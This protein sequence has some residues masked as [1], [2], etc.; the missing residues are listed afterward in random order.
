MLDPL[1]VAGLA[2]AIFEQLLKLGERRREVISDIRSFEQDWQQ[3]R[4]KVRHQ[5]WRMK[6]LHLLFR[7][8]RIY[9]GECLV[10]QFDSDAQG[11]IHNYLDELYGLLERAL[12]MLK[13]V[14]GTENIS[15]TGLDSGFPSS[16]TT[17]VG[18]QSVL[19]IKPPS[20]LQPSPSEKS[21]KRSPLNQLR[22]SFRDKK[23]MVAI[24]G[25]FAEVNNELLE[26]VR[27]WSLAS[28]IGVDIRH[29]EHLRTDQDAGK[30]GLHDDASLALTVAD[31]KNIIESFELED[32]WSKVLK[33]ARTVE[34]RFA[35]F[36]WNKENMLRESCTYSQ[37]HE[38]KLDPQTRNRI[39]LLAKL[40]YQ[41]KETFFCIPP[42][43]GWSYCTNSNQI[44]YL[45]KLPSDLRLE[46]KSLLLL[47]KNPQTQPPLGTKFHIAHSLARSIAQLHLVQWVHE[48][49]RS[50]NILFFPSNAI[51]V[52][53]DRQDEASI[54][55]DLTR[56]LIFGF[57]FSRPDSFFSAGFIDACPDRDVYRHPE[58]QGQ[59]LTIFKKIHDI[60]SLGIILLEI[61]IWRPAIML[62][63]H[64]FAHARDSQG[65]PCGITQHLTKHAMKHLEKP[66]GAK[67]RDIVLK[68]ISGEFGVSNDTREDLKLQQAFRIQ[69]VEV[70]RKIVETL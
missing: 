43:Q 42:C 5:I 12:R 24:I 2:L 9:G 16:A 19:S 49:F 15:Q 48:S 1:S 50:E 51:E 33:E 66:M 28:A 36:D 20:P 56:P 30:L 62:E 41:P 57:E 47:L 68:C 3:L 44:S 11:Q 54:D 34:D 29:L 8:F 38:S 22:W 32:A 6:S 60:Y 55:V 35:V 40:L 7:D 4:E 39:N 18:V 31:T 21:V 52:D 27:F 46:P 61:G 14:A 17:L 26:M 58:R 59:P 67:Y 53:G 10:Q 23:E 25:H 13:R 63:K 64:Q 45:F 65:R 69:V 70:L 37:E